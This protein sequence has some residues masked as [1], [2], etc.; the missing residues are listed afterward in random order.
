MEDKTCRRHPAG[1]CYRHMP[2]PAERVYTAV[3][4][5]IPDRVPVVPK[6]FVD[7]A[8]AI[9]GT[10]LRAVIE[11]PLT[12]LMVILDAGMA[13]GV[14]AVR[15]FHF[16]PRRTVSEN[17]RVCEVDE[18]G[19][20]IGEID[21]AGGLTTRLFDAR[22][23]RLEDT[24]RMAYVQF[25]SS[26]EPFVNGV[27][28]VARMSIPTR[29]FY[30]QIGCGERQREI[31]RIAGDRIG[32]IGDCIS[33]TLCFCLYF[34]GYERALFDLVDQPRL[35]HALMRKGVEYAVERGKFNIDLGLKV[36]RLNDSVG[37][38]SVISPAHWREFIFPHMKEVCEELHRYSPEVKIYSHICG[39][40]LPIAEDLVKTGL[41]CIGPL[42]PL[43]HFTPRQVRERVGGSVA[44]M[45]GVNTLSFLAEGPQQV[46]DEARSCI[47]GAGAYGGYVLGSGCMIPPGSRKEN[48]VALVAAAEH[49][50]VYRDGK[51]AEPLPA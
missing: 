15:Q 44:L 8:S 51:L 26:D 31:M 36:L 7:S 49:Y 21:I 42:D 10:P 50:G 32:I 29:K 47:E 24:Y 1:V 35:V 46:I 2:I 22:E 17:D 25:W 19:R 34:R 38:M 5:G 3:A 18:T 20:R 23:L 33:A 37:N 12:A 13:T 40:I 39:N 4:G 6:I 9:T 28:D 14:D 30:Q 41:D 43:G 16:P 11:D 48:L 27:E 45:G